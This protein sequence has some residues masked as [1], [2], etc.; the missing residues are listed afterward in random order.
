MNKPP[1]ILFK[2]ASRSRRDNFFRGLD[3]IVNN[4]SDKGSYHVQCVFDYDDLEMAD[5]FVID[6]LKTYN[7]LTYYFGISR[8][9]IHAIN[10][11]SDKYQPFHILVNMSD[12]QIFIKH[13]FDV[14]IR[15]AFNG[16][17]DLSVHFPDQAVKDKLI[18][19]SIMG[20]DFYKRFNYIYNSEYTSVYCDNEFTE[21]S[22]ILN[23]YKFVN[24]NIFHHLHY[25]FGLAEMDEQYKKTERP[26]V[27]VKDRETYLRR[28]L[29]NF[30]L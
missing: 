20:V 25:R 22:K 4:L 19:M 8:N 10:R 5:P 15:N 24:E 27:Y 21:V 29:V 17:F 9:K 12:D 1:V 18:T 2:Y 13:G 23:R 3:S 30:E 14:D 7:N 16:D 6:R 26:S 28:K 11:N